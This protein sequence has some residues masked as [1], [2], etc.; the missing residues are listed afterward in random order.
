MDSGQEEV[1]VGVRGQ[2]ARKCNIPTTMRL[3]FLPFSRP[4]SSQTKVAS[5]RWGGEGR[6]GLLDNAEVHLCS[7]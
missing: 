1:G 7:G 4:R 5:Y 6:G 2:Q 3:G